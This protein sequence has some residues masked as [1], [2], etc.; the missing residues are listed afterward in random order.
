MSAPWAHDLH[1]TLNE[2]S[3][4]SDVPGFIGKNHS[5]V[6]SEM[7]KVGSTSQRQSHSARSFSRTTH[8]A[9]VQIRVYIPGMTTPVTYSAAP[10][11][12][13]TR[14][15]NHRPPLRRDKPVRVSLPHQTPRYIFPSVEKSFIFIPRALRPNQQGFGR[16]K[17]RGPLSAYGAYSSRRTS[18]YGGSVYSSSIVLSRRSSLAREVTRDSIVSPS[19]STFSRPQVPLNEGGKPVVRLP[20][21]AQYLPEFVP[22]MPY[23]NSFGNSTDIPNHT[24]SPSYTLPKKGEYIESWPTHLPMHQ[25]RPKKTISMTDIEP[26]VSSSSF[27]VPQPQEQQPFHQQMPAKTR[28][29]AHEIG[30]GRAGGYQH[31]HQISNHSE[32]GSTDTPLPNIPERAIHAPAFQPIQQAYTGHMASYYYPSPVPVDA[33]GQQQ[34]SHSGPPQQPVPQHQYAGGVPAAAA[35]VMAPIFVPG[36]QPNAFVM[37]PSNVATVPPGSAAGTDAPAA[38]MVPAGVN[39]MAGMVAH[40][41]NGMV[42]YY[43]PS[44]M[45]Q[46]MEGYQSYPHYSPAAQTPFAYTIPAGAAGYYYP[47]QHMGAAD[48]MYYP[49][50][51]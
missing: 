37:P 45:Y 28:N 38:A 41:S 21:V 19:G 50:S 14:L 42:Y 25:P 4:R 32:A 46:P 3:N 49:P 13:H 26:S 47:Q 16:G 48:A 7:Q 31:N 34:Q 2:P 39:G 24:P 51:G 36:S 18:A 20:T 43:D 33:A 22:I 17:P 9:N 40:E 1:H 15:P 27:Y 6:P 12:Q 5:L 29:S 30:P 35:P 8:V 10:V 11:K 23:M 44:Q